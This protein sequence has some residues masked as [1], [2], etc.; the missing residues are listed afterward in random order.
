MMPFGRQKKVYSRGL[1]FR[2]LSIS[3]QDC[4]D[5]KTDQQDHVEVLHDGLLPFIIRRWFSM[6][7]LAVQREIETLLLHIFTD[8]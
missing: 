1:R 4:N 2:R 6:H 7:S 3:V 8:A 5:G